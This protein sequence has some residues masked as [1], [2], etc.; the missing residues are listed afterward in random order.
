MDA[1][2]HPRSATSQGRLVVVSGPS[3]VGKSSLLA[4][5]LP[6]VGG[7]FSVSATTRAPR[8]GEQDGR[9]YFFVSHERFERMKQQGLLLEWA[10]VFDNLYGTPAQP[11]AEAVKAGRL[12]VLDIDVQGAIQV[13]RKLPEALFVL[14]VPPDIA[15]LRTRLAG[16]KTETPQQLEARLAKAQQELQTARDSGIYDHEVTNDD[17]DA[18]AQRLVQIVQQES[19]KA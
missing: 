13:H 18:A 10:S 4:R 19:G 6:A 11:V 1:V 16:R 14:V 8:P 17:L 9:E 2:S 3:G 12:V 5:V 15:T 7:V